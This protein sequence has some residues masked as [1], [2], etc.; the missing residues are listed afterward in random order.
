MPKSQRAKQFA[1]FAGLAGL[2]FALG[3]KE[4]EA[5]LEMRKELSQENMNDIDLELLRIRK[6][7]TALVRFF[8]GGKILSAAGRVIVNSP[9][10][11]MIRVGG[12][13]IKYEDLYAVYS[14]DAVCGDPEKDIV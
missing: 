7:D 2:E 8:S 10:E 6:G 1:L 14:G 9:E 11:Q 13:E 12:T 4:E 3:M 5:E